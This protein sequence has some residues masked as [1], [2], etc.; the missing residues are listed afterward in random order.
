VGYGNRSSGPHAFSRADLPLENAI[1]EIA[2]KISVEGIIANDAVFLLRNLSR[3]I[4]IGSGEQGPNHITAKAQKSE[5]LRKNINIITEKTVK[6]LDISKPEHI[7]EFTNFLNVLRQSELLSFVPISF[8]NTIVSHTQW[9][10]NNKGL[11]EELN[12]LSFEQ[13][14][15][16]LSDL[17]HHG[18]VAGVA[19]RFYSLLPDTSKGGKKK[20]E[21]TAAV[22]EADQ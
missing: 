17:I 19:Q 11:A 22:N 12:A 9:I 15:K 1:G 14:S 13:V 18:T 5:D 16:I 4:A 20:E 10:F 7:P 8:R 3:K 6:I 21:T 2:A